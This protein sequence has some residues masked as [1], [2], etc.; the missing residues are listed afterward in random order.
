MNARIRW[1]RD[2]WGVS[3]SAT[4]LSRFY[5]SSLNLEDGSR[6][7]IPSMTRFNASVDYSFD[8][9]ESESKVRFGMN[10]L[11][12]ERAP[13]ADRYFG[14]FADAHNDMGRSYYLDL[15]LAF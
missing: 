1:R 3:A 13:L 9:W 4:Y 12:N 7:I 11:T 6:W 8:M 2:S 15:R 10:N 5:Q 14:Y